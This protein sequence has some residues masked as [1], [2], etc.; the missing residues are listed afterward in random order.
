M[1]HSSPADLN[2]HSTVLCTNAKGEHVAIGHLTA[3]PDKQ[4]VS[5]CVGVIESYCGNIRQLTMFSLRVD[6]TYWKK[7]GAGEHGEA[8]KT[9]EW[10]LFANLMYKP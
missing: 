7:I 4:E 3:D 9:D 8:P 5:S 10:R 2:V 1:D 6:N